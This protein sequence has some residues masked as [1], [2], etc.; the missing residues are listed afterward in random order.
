MQFSKD[1]IKRGL[2][3]FGA[4]GPM[5]SDVVTKESTPVRFGARTEPSLDDIGRMISAAEKKI[6]NLRRWL[7]E[8]KRKS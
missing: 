2:K 1:Q 8:Q 6:A 7:A 4:P 3:M 5:T